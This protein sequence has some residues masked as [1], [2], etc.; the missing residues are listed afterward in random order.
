MI[1]IK[2]IIQ[3][4]R[5]NAPIYV[6][7]SSG[8]GRLFKRRTRESINPDYWNTKKGA[9]KN[10]T[11]LKEADLNTLNEITDKLNRLRA[12]LFREFSN[13]P[14]G[15]ITGDWLTE[16]IEDFYNGKKSERLDYLSEY[17]NYYE[18][19]YLPSQKTMHKV[20]K[21]RFR[22][23]IKRLKDFFSADLY[24]LRVRDLTA[25]KLGQFSGYLETKGLS[26]NTAIDRIIL[27]KFM[28]KHAPKLNIEVSRD[29]YEYQEKFSKTPTPYLTTEELERIK[30]LDLQDENLIIAR[31]W[32]FV[33]CYTG[34]RISDFIR[35]SKEMITTI[36]GREYIVLT[37]EKTGA[38]VMIPLHKEVEEVLSRYDGNF[39]PRRGQST[40]HDTTILNDGIKELCRLAAIN[41]LE[42]GRIYDKEQK[43]YIHGT[44]PL[45]Q[46]ASSHICRRSFA[47]NHYGKVPTPVIM[48]VTGHKQEKV[49]LNYIGVDDSTLSEQIFNYWD[50]I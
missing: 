4:K 24:K 33:G 25:L 40:N 37:Q 18:T 7:L 8:R 10:L 50:K 46:I 23:V 3:S 34:Q 9:I 1:T 45:Y 35:M 29:L 39:P 38:N 5:K 43:R 12:Y 6:Y 26:R 20:R 31:D 16:R 42:R 14:S 2:Y 22:N 32:L 11:S 28:L 44:Y 15:E 17:L 13:S 27:V 19:E 47:S 30:K 49:F 21:Q 36:K 41:R 48:S